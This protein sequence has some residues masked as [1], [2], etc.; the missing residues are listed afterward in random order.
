MKTIN[1]YLLALMAFVG[2]TWT[3]CSDSVDYDPGMPAEGNGMFFADDAP[4]SVTLE[5]TDGSFSVDIYRSVTA[6]TAQASITSLVSEEG[7]GLFTVPSSASFADGADKATLNIAYTN[8]VR[9]TRYQITLSLGDGTPYGA[10]TLSLTVTYPEEEEVWDVVST[11]AILIDNIFSGFGVKN[12]QISGI[13]VEKNPDPNVNQYRFRSPYDNSYFTVVYGMNLFPS[14]YKTP[15]IILDGDAYAEEEPGSYYIAPTNLGF[16]MVNGAGP[17]MDET[18][19]TFGSVAGNLATADGPV[20][21]PNAAY[22]LGSYD[23][24]T[25]AFDLGA[26][27]HNIGD[28]GFTVISGGSMRLYLDP[29]LMV[30]DYDRDYTWYDVYNAAG[31]FTSELAEGQWQQPVQRAAEDPTFYRL[32]SVYA[33]D[34]HI[35]FNYDAENG[36]FSMPRGQKTGLK[37][38]VGNQDIYVSGVPG[39]FAIDEED[40]SL[41]HFNMSFYLADEDGNATAELAQM[42]ET[43]LWGQGVYDAFAKNAKL[44]D[45]VGNWTVTLTD[46]QGIV[47]VPV[48]VAKVKD[49]QGG[50]HLL[51]AGLSGAYSE[52]YNDA[53][54]LVYDAES[55]Y[56]LFMFQQSGNFPADIDEEGNPVYYASYAAPF[57]SELGAPDVSGA[58]VLVGGLTADGQL[59]F[60]DNLTNSMPYDGMIYMVT[61]DGANLY[62]LTGF[63]NLLT[64]DPYTGGGNQVQQ[65]LAP[66]KTMKAVKTTGVKKVSRR[67]YKTTI[68]LQPQPKTYSLQVTAPV[69]GMKFHA[70][71]K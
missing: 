11:E 25:K 14:D 59:Q 33:P 53:V 64:W 68:D 34:V 6:G 41:L 29:D 7:D 52:T 65:K 43:F 21:P 57:N 63:W 35:Y 60:A 70:V 17:K 24:A 12:L 55:G 13:T 47:D 39:G 32:P 54:E 23:E 67:E 36:T 2:L 69:G 50:D 3:A 26:V 8:V 28:F 38:N 51:A 31:T 5:G 30:P 40:P 18:W 37:T 27:Y 1:T 56:T 4:T 61:P 10:S 16:Q 9:G 42:D 58:D 48:T 15:Y 46:G 19:D 45:Y 62:L 71:E 20:T 49:Q 66:M 44:D 22:P